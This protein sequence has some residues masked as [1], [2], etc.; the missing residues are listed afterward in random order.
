MRFLGIDYGTKRIGVAISDL[1]GVLAFPKEIVSNDIN[2][3]EKIGEIINTENISEIIIGES[4]DFSGKLNALSARI[5]IFILELN[6]R[7]KLPIHKQKEF[8]TSVEARKAGSNKR[9]LSQSQVHSKVKQIKSGRIDASAAALI[10]QRY[11]DKIN[12]IKK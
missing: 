7:F 3:F 9:T 5:E 12:N 1:N 6:N 4:V 8:L 2:S 10:L 11:L